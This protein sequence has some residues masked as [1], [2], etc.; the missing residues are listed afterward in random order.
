MQFLFVS[1]MKRQRMGGECVMVRFVIALLAK[2]YSSDQIK[3]KEMGW[4]CSPYGKERRVAL[5][6]HEGKRLF[7]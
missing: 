6:R 1:G 4:A 7:G 2:Y 3:K 5:G